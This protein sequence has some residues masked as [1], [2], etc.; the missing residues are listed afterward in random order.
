LTIGIPL[1]LP[2]NPLLK[3]VVAGTDPVSLAPFFV[4]SLL[5][6]NKERFTFSFGSPFP[7]PLALSPPLSL[8]FQ[9]HVGTLQPLM[10]DA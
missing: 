9:D 2:D 1:L 5:G 7:R 8:S 10:E 4:A 3:S 6:Q